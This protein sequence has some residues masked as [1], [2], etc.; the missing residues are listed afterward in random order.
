MLRAESKTH[1]SHVRW[2][3][4]PVHLVQVFEM[5]ALFVK[6]SKFC[7]ILRLVKRLVR[8]DEFL[9]FQNNGGIC[10]ALFVVNYS[11]RWVVCTLVPI[12]RK[13]P[14]RTTAHELRV[15]TC[16]WMCAREFVRVNARVQAC[17]PICA[18]THTHIHTHT[19][20]HTHLDPRGEGSA[21][22]GSPW[23]ALHTRDES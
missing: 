9:L 7:E 14:T 23:Q 8:N 1:S 6:L 20:T 21:H 10:C 17:T 16:D 15:A 12:A 18:S 22:N 19:H 11:R 4:R 13:R 2:Q 5:L 3:K